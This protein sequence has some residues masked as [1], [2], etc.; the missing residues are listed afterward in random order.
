MRAFANYS[1]YYDL[2]YKDKDYSGEV[3]Y[4]HS[5]LQRYAPHTNSI[6]DLG[7]G[8]GIHA[9]LLAKKGYEVHGIDVS[10]KMLRTAYQR[11][12]HLPQEEVKRLSFAQGNVQSYRATRSF[13]AVISLFHVM[14][15]QT[16]NADL[17]AAFVTAKAHLN[18]DGVF[19]FD[20]WYG[21]AVLTDLPEVRI[22]RLEDEEVHVTRVA[23][24]VLIPN[25]NRVDVKYTVLIED[26]HTGG[27]EKVQE[28]HSMRYLFAPEVE[29][30][31]ADSG[32]GW[33]NAE[34]W[35]S[36][37]EPGF[38]TWGVCFVGKNYGD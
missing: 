33:T 15:Y 19:I 27:L 26:K 14:S 6:L 25:S 23:E 38:G 37:K 29:K 32:L 35:V 22:K 10:E 16:T 18:P 20:C 9:V 36:G 17:L 2:L 8:T 24:P 4:I 31:F 34:E 3:N 5:L 28:T 21:P 7:C 13:D 1:K 11:L 30:L 12:V